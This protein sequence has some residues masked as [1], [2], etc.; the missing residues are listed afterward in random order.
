MAIHPIEVY[1]TF[2]F[3]TNFHTGVLQDIRVN[4]MPTYAR[5]PKVTNTGG[6]VNGLYHT[7]RAK[8][9]KQAFI[10]FYNFINDK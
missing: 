7:V 5:K 1:N 10:L 3:E 2:V 8:T 9:M 6:T 4:L